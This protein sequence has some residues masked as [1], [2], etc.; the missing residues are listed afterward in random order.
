MNQ[1]Q[2]VL[3]IL[4][5]LKRDGTCTAELADEY[6]YYGYSASHKSALR[7]AQGDMKLVK[8]FFGEGVLVQYPRGHYTLINQD[9]MDALLP[10][11][12]D[13][14]SFR[15][16]FEF[17]ILFDDTI[18]NNI[19]DKK[20]KAYIEKVKKDVNEIYSIHSDPI[21]KL[22]TKHIN[23]LKQAIKHNRYINLT[24]DNGKKM[25]LN[26][27]QPH[28]IVFAQ[29]NW[30]LAT[31]EPNSKVNKGFRFLRIARIEEVKILPETF[32]CNQD[33]EK[34]IKNFQSLF[35]NFKKPRYRVEIEV[36]S[37]IAKYFKEKKH[38]KSQQIVG[39]GESGNLRVEYFIN[40]DLEILPL[41]KKW[42]PDIKIRY[43]NTLREKFYEDLDKIYVKREE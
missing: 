15:K 26:T 43:P 27:I 4:K 7:T 17:L 21:E 34:F 30:Y 25:R 9:Y 35:T 16:F 20:Q 24:V 31:F 18:L 3:E 8:D 40:H 14:D 39:Y 11:A 42:I 19:V 36:S 28:R 12:Q 1:A 41:I 22:N 2:R 32:H 6:L 38:L 37:R 33:V 23:V 29:G 13:S 5:R 10:S